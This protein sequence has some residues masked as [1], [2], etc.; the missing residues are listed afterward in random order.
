[1]ATSV[2]RIYE[3]SETN[4]GLQNPHDPDGRSL[5][6][7][8]NLTTTAHPQVPSSGLIPTA[9]QDCWS[10]PALSRST[11]VPGERFQEVHGAVQ[12]GASRRRRSMQ[13]GDGYAS[14]PEPRGLKPLAL[15]QSYDVNLVSPHVSPVPP[16]GS[17]CDTAWQ[18]EGSTPDVCAPA[19]QMHPSMGRGSP[20]PSAS[21]FTRA[22]R[23]VY[24]RQRSTSRASYAQGMSSS[25]SG[26]FAAADRLLRMHENRYV[27]YSGPVFLPAPPVASTLLLRSAL[28]LHFSSGNSSSAVLA[29]HIDVMSSCLDRQ[30][31]YAT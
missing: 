13:V 15:H 16:P 8:S 6:S 19:A 29:D 21:S 23:R 22:D 30:Q 1:V 28:Q 2:L 17:P 31:E 20:T 25:P 27:W 4:V 12:N 7:I 3:C 18:R 14:G 11:G 24:T 10:G 26:E 9:V 5:G